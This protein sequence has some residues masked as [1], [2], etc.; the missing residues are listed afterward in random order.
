MKTFKNWLTFVDTRARGRST[1]LVLGLL[2]ASFLLPGLSWAGDDYREPPEPGQEQSQHQ[3]Q[4]QAQGQHQGQETTVITEASIAEGAV[5]INQNRE[6]QG[7]WEIRFRNNPNVYA[8][9]IQPTISC[10]KTGGGGA[11]GG[12]VGL[13]FGGGKIDSACVEREEIRLGH[14]LGHEEVALFRFCS[15][16]NNVAAFGSVGACVTYDSSPASA[17]YQLLMIEKNRLERELRETHELM[18]ARCQ[19]AEEAGARTE[20]AWLECLAK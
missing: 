3:G 7:D 12:G 5:T 19:A 13:S 14:L 1:S 8:P 10:Y 2:T 15:L 4:G 18:V 20:E 11:S 16:A 17:E 6:A 9:A